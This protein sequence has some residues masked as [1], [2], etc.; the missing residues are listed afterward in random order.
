MILKEKKMKE[1]NI[2]NIALKTQLKK[3]IEDEIEALQKLEPFTKNEEE[4]NKILKMYP[5]LNEINDSDAKN[6]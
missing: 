2:K 4:I 3:K 6:I 5:N 1:K